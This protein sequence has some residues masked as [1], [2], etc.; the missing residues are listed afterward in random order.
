MKQH[1]ALGFSVKLVTTDIDPKWAPFDQLRKLVGTIDIAI[2]NGHYLF[3]FPLSEDRKGVRSLADLRCYSDPGLVNKAVEIYSRLWES[4]LT[5][6]D[7]ERLAIP[8]AN[9]QN[10]KV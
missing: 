5:Q 10:Q 8:E 1:K 2:I 7:V 6:E 9:G 3:A 4:G